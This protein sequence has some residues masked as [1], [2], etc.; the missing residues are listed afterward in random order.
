MLKRKH[1]RQ[2][3]RI[4][5]TRFFQQFKEGDHVAVVREHSE[6]FGYS[7]RV[8]GK[9]GKVI[10]KQGEAYCVEISDLGKL[11]RYFIKPIHLKRIATQ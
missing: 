5:F 6:I 11:K 4:S 2:R 1:P 7:T 9:T 8:Q 10:C 3:G